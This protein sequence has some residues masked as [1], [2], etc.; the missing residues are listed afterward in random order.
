[1]DYT[2]AIRKLVGSLDNAR[3]RR[4]TGLFK[5]EGWKCVA[6]TL[7]YFDTELLLLSHERL[8]AMRQRENFKEI[9]ESK[10][11]VVPNRDFRRMTSLSTASDIIAVYKIPD[12]RVDKA[13]LENKLVLALD[14]IQDPGNLGTILRAADWFGVQD[15]ICSQNTADPYSPKTVMASMGAISRVRPKKCNLKDIIYQSELTVYGT[16]LAGTDIYKADLTATGIIV[17]GSEGRGMSDEIAGI[18]DRHLFIP[19]YPGDSP[20]SESLNVG[21]ATSIILSEFRRRLI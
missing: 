18:V 5:A 13:D 14:G 7:G 9:D 1:M 20:T 4:E 16:S 11:V 8:V 2:N 17:M 3:D 6:D 19:P 12:S 15:V 10:I 21:M